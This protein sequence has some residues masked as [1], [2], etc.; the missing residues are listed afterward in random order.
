MGEGT[1]KGQ[2]LVEGGP[3]DLHGG[4]AGIED[5]AVLVVVDVG[6]ILQEPVGTRHPDGDDPVVLPGGV[7]HPAC[8]TLVF[9]A[10]LALGIAGLGRQLGGGNGLGVLFR[11]RQ[12]DGDVH[13]AVFAGDLPAHVPGDAVA[14]DVVGVA[15][16]FVIPVCGSLG[17]LGVFFGKGAAHLPGHGGQGAHELRVEE[18]PGHHV[19]FAQTGLAGVVQQPRQNLLQILA[20]GLVGGGVGVQL[21]QLQDPVYQDG[22]VLRLG[23]ACVH[24]IGHKGVNTGFKFHGISSSLA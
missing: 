20:L 5:D 2:Q 21:Q 4:V 14:A 24:G 17:G 23:Q 9:G 10:Q 16:E 11:L 1:H 12:V 3:V 13:I 18:V 6:G 22:V 15:A 7:I 8:V 19:V